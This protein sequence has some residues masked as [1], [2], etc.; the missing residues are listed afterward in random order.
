MKE[1]A[2]IVCNKDK[3][4]SD[5]NRLK[6]LPIDEYCQYLIENDQLDDRDNFDK[7]SL[8][9]IDILKKI[10]TYI[11]IEILAKSRVLISPYHDDIDIIKKS[12]W[13]GKENKDIIIKVLYFF[14]NFHIYTKNKKIIKLLTELIYKN[15]LRYLE[16]I[17][18]IIKQSIFHCNN[19]YNIDTI[20]NN[21]HFIRMYFPI[22]NIPIIR[23]MKYSI[24]NDLFD[25]YSV[26]AKKIE[27]IFIEMIFNSY[28]DK[29]NQKFVNNNGNSNIL[30]LLINL[31]NKY[32]KNLSIMRYTSLLENSSYNLLYN[33]INYV[34][35]NF[36]INDYFVIG[37][38]KCE[39]NEQLNIIN[40]LEEL[41]YP[42]DF[43][44]NLHNNLNKKSI[45][46]LK[47]NYQQNPY[48]LY[49]NKET[50]NK[51]KE[52][53]DVILN[54]S[55]FKKNNIENTNFWHLIT[56]IKD[57]EWKEII[58]IDRNLYLELMNLYGNCRDY[59][60]K[61]IVESLYPLSNLQNK[62]TYLENVKFNILVR[63]QTMWDCENLEE[64]FKKRTFCGFSIIN[65]DNF[66]HY[67]DSILYG[68]YT[69]ITPSLIAHIYPQD[70]LSQSWANYEKDLTKKLNYLLDINDLNRITYESKTYNQLCVRTKTQTGEILRHNCIVFTD[71]N[72]K[73]IEIVEKSDNKILILRK[74]SHTIENNDDIYKYLK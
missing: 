29:I 19:K 20:T 24:E 28:F 42:N 38:K 54:S 32:Q 22:Q 34:P 47:I 49:L 74:N 16:I 72:D 53:Y 58:S 39:I 65:E 35:K 17:L 56:E 51:L 46:R 2:K 40:S 64:S 14:Q 62:I 67:G 68:Y 3:I 30:Y 4:I 11:F 71:E 7:E 60:T 26:C 66:S 25:I 27:P 50:S 52:I 36:I 59:A 73:R 23:I 70:S 6:D 1:L 15:N 41:E 45:E 43:I 12:N 44:N 21:D 48:D 33:I 31:S 61:S 63:V 8:E 18:E 37:F 5:Y 55:Y 69:G 9:I 10:D 57:N 13:I